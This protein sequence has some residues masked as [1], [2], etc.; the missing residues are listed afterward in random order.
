MI[1]GL[2]ICAARE[3]PDVLGKQNGNGVSEFT[4][5]PK[6][7]AVN[8]KGTEFRRL[9]R[10]M[11]E[12]PKDVRAPRTQQKVNLQSSPLLNWPSDQLMSLPSVGADEKTLHQ[13]IQDGE[14]PTDEN[15][16]GGT[17]NESIP[18]DLA[19]A[20]NWPSDYRASLPSLGED[21]KTSH[22]QPQD[23]VNA[24]DMVNE[25]MLRVAQRP[26][27]RE[28]S[29]ID[30]R[31]DETEN[32]DENI[33]YD[34]EKSKQ[35]A[36]DIKQYWTDLEGYRG[37]LNIGDRQ[38]YRKKVEDFRLSLIEKC[39]RQKIK[40]GRIKFLC[41]GLCGTAASSLAIFNVGPSPLS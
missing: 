29:I 32:D 6:E 21:E 41:A 5:L 14:P 4:E 26:R 23:M 37:A 20:T 17:V 25:T 2:T 34:W 33:A 36:D 31:A 19:P 22:Q 27:L 3:R 13:Q 39:T 24:E 16:V 7:E 1:F 38:K 10:E 12:I 15:D 18:L 28:S 8:S 35:F 30:I 9:M 11:V 40:V